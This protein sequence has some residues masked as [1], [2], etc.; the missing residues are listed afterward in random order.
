MK[1]CG[2]S[3]NLTADE[4]RRFWATV[5][6]II[7]P[8]WMIIVA[9]ADAAEFTADSDAISK[10]LNVDQTFV[11]AHARRL[12]KQGHIQCTRHNGIIKLSLTTAA[13]AKLTALLPH[14]KT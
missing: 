3:D 8:E 12:E 7:G 4:R 14:G 1:P 6:G 9:L 5:F 2:Q 13:V 11:H 10:T